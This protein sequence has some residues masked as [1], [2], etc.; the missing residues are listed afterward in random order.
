MSV[1]A[2][3]V[4]SQS[5]SLT[6]CRR[7]YPVQHGMILV[8]AS[9]RTLTAFSAAL[10][11]TVLHE[12]PRVDLVRVY[13]KRLDP[14]YRIT[15]SATPST[16]STVDTDSSPTHDRSF[17][18]LEQRL[19]RR[20]QSTAISSIS[21]VSD[22]ATPSTTPPTVYANSSQTRAPR[23]IRVRI[24]ARY[25]DHARQ[26]ED[27]CMVII[28]RF[29]AMADYTD[30]LTDAPT[31]RSVQ[32]RT[33]V[34]PPARDAPDTLLSGHNGSRRI[35]S[36]PPEGPASGGSSSPENVSRSA[37]Q[38]V[39]YSTLPGAYDPVTVEAIP[40]DIPQARGHVRE[41]ENPDSLALLVVAPERNGQY[42]PRVA[43]T[44]QKLRYIFKDAIE[45]YLK[46]KGIKVDE[47]VL[48]EFVK[49]HT[50]AHDPTQTPFR[51]SEM[52]VRATGYDFHAP[53]PSSTYISSAGGGIVAGI[54]F[55]I[56]I[57]IVSEFTLFILTMRARFDP[58]MLF[59]FFGVLHRI[60][61]IVATFER[62]VVRLLLKVVGTVLWYLERVLAVA[63]EAAQE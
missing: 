45:W 26:C 46:E 25:F 43:V 16:T 14:S 5:F 51:I 35:S 27:R 60:K 28:T 52:R 24:S 19:G 10:L 40:G 38:Q 17:V 62:R 63:R 8:S 50:Q 6:D 4:Q 22:S 53:P 58:G 32:H 44:H 13:D 33:Y 56:F 18:S 49:V 48:G 55:A 37:T 31:D 9:W 21:R 61:F 3:K 39:T 47:G 11:S 57:I 29:H 23:V 36:E 15:D 59:Q 12:E 54:I 34:D 30:V 20:S 42:H 2:P 1:R 7:G 41:L